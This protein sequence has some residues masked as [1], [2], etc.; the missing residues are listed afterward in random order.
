[1]NADKDFAIRILLHGLKG[2]IEGKSYPSVMVAMND[3]SDE[4]VASIVS[5]I[6]YEFVGSFVRVG[7]GRQSPVVQVE[8]IKKIR[9]QHPNKT[10]PWTIEE[11]EKQSLDI[12]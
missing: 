8:D 5:Y 11:L 4:W 12:N 10:E 2:P 9:E 6:R 3:N 1:M 7:K